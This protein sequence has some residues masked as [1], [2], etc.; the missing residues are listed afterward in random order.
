[1]RILTSCAGITIAGFTMLATAHAAPQILAA[2]PTTEPVAFKCHG[3][4]CTAELQTIC[5]EEDRMGPAPGTVYHAA[6]KNMLQLSGTRPDGTKIALGDK[7]K[8]SITSVRRWTTVRVSVPQK[9][10]KDLG[11]QSVAVQVGENASLIPAARPGDPEPHDAMGIAN[12]TGPKRMIAAAV[13]SA[14]R[15]DM[16]AAQYLSKLSYTLSPIEA[17]RAQGNVAYWRKI[18]AM[19]D[20][21]PQGSQIAARKAYDHCRAV[22]FGIENQLPSCLRKTS[23]GIMSVITT[24]YWRDVKPIF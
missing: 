23:D 9:R 22:T 17:A 5:L 7:V 15:G 12:V 2:A 19:I 10:L 1:M 6:G 3:G 4:I 20:Q 8:M 13:M 14:N 16:K 11:L 24:K 18:D 21:A